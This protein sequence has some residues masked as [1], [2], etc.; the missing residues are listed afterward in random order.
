[1]ESNTNESVGQLSGLRGIDQQFWNWISRNWR[2]AL[3]GFFL[4]N[5]ALKMPFLGGSSLFLDEAV[6]IYDTQGSVLETI[7]FSA[8]DPTPPLYYL[9]VGLWCKVFGISEFSARFPSMLF[10]SA[11]A[12]LLFLLGFRHFNVRAG[13]FAA[14]LFTVSGVAMV[15]AHEARAY[16]LASMLMVI[17]Y[18]L[19]LDIYRA[20]KPKWQMFLGIA[21]V[22]A[23]LLY[24]HYLTSM[25]IAA[26]AMMSL[27]LLRGKI[28]HLFRYA[29]SQLLVLA[30]WLPWV[31]Y[32][33][34]L[35]SDSKVT[36]WLKAPDPSVLNYVLIH[37][38]GSRLLKWIAFAV[39]VVGA[40]AAIY[41]FTRTKKPEKGGFGLVV[42]AGWFFLS[43]ALQYGTAKLVM[44]VF[45]LRYAMY[46]LPGGIL[47]IG[48]LISYLP[49]PKIL[50]Y[51][52]VSTQL[53]LSLVLLNLNPQNVENWRDASALVKDMKNE[54]SAMMVMAHYQYVPFSYYFNR[55]YFKDYK[56]T[57]DLF[58][59][60]N[61]HFGQDTALLP[62]IDDS[63]VTNIIL[64][65]SHDELVDPKALVFNYLKE[66]YCINRR[67]AF[68]GVKVYQFQ[69]PPCKPTPGGHFVEDFET[70]KLPSEAGFYMV[71]PDSMNSSNKGT[72][73]GPGHEF[74]ASSSWN[75]ADIHQG[76]FSAAEVKVRGKLLDEGK[77]VVAVFVME[78]AGEAYNWIGFELQQSHGVGVWF[79][80]SFQ[81]IIP[82]IKSP[83]DQV[84]VYFWSPDGGGGEF[85]NLEVDFWEG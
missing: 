25:G 57:T 32:N 50:Q 70:V 51:A 77:K 3:L 20:D 5:V 48:A 78:H 74:S 47:L 23:L 24:T 14:L 55:E 27:W 76:K 52:I 43:L 56:S 49:G 82:E 83:E 28:G 65:L 44:P 64:V 38:A 85:D 4:L 39:I 29:G 66:R 18:L 12:A 41:A 60:D 35:L 21:L 63:L 54:G 26:Q 72:F 80:D 9:T 30:L 17:S 22:N 75:A 69:N 33:R 6:A 31:A 7:D 81:V 34:S 61:I 53:G 37:F 79:E 45:D 59:L 8:N 19:F 58:T 84:K 62:V 11:T 42:A 10:S 2:W 36:S 1:M 67:G 71:M 46:A 68:R 15:F 73:V 16:A 40:I 13:F